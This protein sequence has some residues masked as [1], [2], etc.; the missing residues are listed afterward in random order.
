ME[1]PAGFVVL[2][3]I[4]V[5]FIALM[6]VSR[7]PT[8]AGKTLGSRVPREWAI[9]LLLAVALFITLLVIHPFVLLL[10]LT[11][12]YLGLIPLGVRKYRALERLD[13]RAPRGRPSPWPNLP[14]RRRA[15]A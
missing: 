11:V 6:M 2:E 5:L 15:G 14:R 10:V 9:P 4:Y 1:R 13:K 3:A 8:Y 7:H 12:V